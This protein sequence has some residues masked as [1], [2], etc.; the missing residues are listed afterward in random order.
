MLVRL[1]AQALSHSVAAGIYTHIATK[2][3]FTETAKTTADF[4]DKM[5]S[6]FDM[7]NSRRLI[8]DKPARFALTADNGT[9][10]RLKEL[11]TWIAG[12]KFGNVRS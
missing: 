6:L 4:I 7:L 5:D 10:D 2:Q 12:W 1:A 11:R 8:A 9:I 3:A